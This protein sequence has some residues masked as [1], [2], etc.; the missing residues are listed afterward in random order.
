[1]TIKKKRKW[2]RGTTRKKE[3]K[4][5]RK[6]KR[7]KERKKEKKGIESKLSKLTVV[8][9]NVGDKESNRLKI[10]YLQNLQNKN[11]FPERKFS[12]DCKSN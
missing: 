3:R 4:K 8:K 6:K 12:L 11:I 7:K 9:I 2:E 1:M 5:E 10:N